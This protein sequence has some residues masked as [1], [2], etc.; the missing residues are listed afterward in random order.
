MASPQVLAKSRNWLLSKALRDEDWVLWVDADLK[1]YPADVIDSLLSAN[2][3]VVVPNCVMEPGGRY[4][5]ARLHADVSVN[6][7]SFVWPRSYDLNSWQRPDGGADGSAANNQAN[8][9]LGLSTEEVTALGTDGIVTRCAES[10]AASDA[11]AAEALDAVHRSGVGEMYTLS[12]LG[13]VEWS[14]LTSG[15]AAAAQGATMGSLV[16]GAL[17]AVPAGIVHC[18][19]DTVTAVSQNWGAPDRLAGPA[20]EKLVCAPQWANGGSD[21]LVEGYTNTGN[22]SEV[23]PPLRCVSH[24]DAPCMRVCPSCLCTS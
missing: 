19:R 16:R 9:G 17:A 23:L 3:S 6:A 12:T 22:V 10:I 20:T 8:G 21:L 5:P 18:L 14:E 2:K 24:A 15:P 11:V 1:G 7:A 4:V 13:D